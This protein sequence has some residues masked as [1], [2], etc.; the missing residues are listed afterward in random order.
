L[1]KDAAEDGAAVFGFRG[2]NAGLGYVVIAPILMTIVALVFSDKFCVEV[3]AVCPWG[4]GVV[5]Y[6][7]FSED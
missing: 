5:A 2:A 4:L 6:F 7:V 3:G 1:R